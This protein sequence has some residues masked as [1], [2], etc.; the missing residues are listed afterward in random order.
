MTSA[1]GCRSMAGRRTFFDRD[2]PIVGSAAPGA[3]T[4]AAT[5]DVLGTTLFL[6]GR[7]RF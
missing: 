7:L 6:G 2:P 5:Y 3:N 1:T 4:Y